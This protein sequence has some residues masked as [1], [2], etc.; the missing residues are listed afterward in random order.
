MFSNNL[1]CNIIE[2]IDNNINDKITVEN[3]S[4]RFYFN[5][6][7]IMKLFKRELDITICDYIN[8]KRI[9][10]STKLIKTTNYSM[11]TIGL[12]N[13]FYSLEYFSETFK[14]I[15]GVSP[16]KFKKYCNNRFSFTEEDNYLIINNLIKMQDIIELVNKYKNNR[17]HIKIPVRKLSIF[18]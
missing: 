1:V 10:N 4:K 17:R 7:Y 6:F 13:G 8:T 15:I 18:N 2:Y 3:I 14:K 11:L 16:I 9:Y 5:R 12:L